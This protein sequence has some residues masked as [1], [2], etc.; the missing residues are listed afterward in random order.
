MTHDAEADPWS[1]ESYR[2][3]LR[4]L[5]RMQLDPRLRGKLDPSDVVQQ[6]LLVAHQKRQQFRG[7]S[8]GELAGWLRRI[9]ASELC[10]A[11]RKFHGATRDV[12]HERSL[13][14]AL[15]Q[16]SARLEAWLADDQSSVS[17]RAM[18]QEQLCRLAG[19]LAQLPE[20]QR[21]AVELYHLQGW[22]VP[23]IAAHLGRTEPAVAGL[24]RR[25]LQALRESLKESS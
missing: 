3:Y 1:L 23:D 13:E 11:A 5:A 6:T 22:P 10:T 17:E 15:E 16:S 8:D 25:G 7:H 21:D 4:L 14:G 20:A 12:K 24:V 19:A 9:L 2:E 18:R